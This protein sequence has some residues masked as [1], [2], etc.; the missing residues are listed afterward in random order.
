MIDAHKVELTIR[1]Q[2]KKV[3]FNFFKSMKYPLTNNDVHECFQ[4]D[5]VENVIEY[6]FR[7][8]IC[9]DYLDYTMLNF[10]DNPKQAKFHVKI[11]LRR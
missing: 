11:A 9:N 5:V 1:V 10:V 8:S 6:M 4:I 7:D 3:T 2:D